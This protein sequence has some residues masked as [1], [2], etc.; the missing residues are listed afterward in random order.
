MAAVHGSCATSECRGLAV[1][2]VVLVL[3]G[4]ALPTT[5]QVDATNQV[6]LTLSATIDAS[7]ITI[8]VSAP[9]CEPTT[10]ENFPDIVIR[11]RNA[12]TGEVGEGAVAVGGFTAPGV[13]SAV[14]PSGTP[15]DSFLV[16]VTCN[17]GALEGSQAF[18]LAAPAP[19][20]VALQPNF[21]G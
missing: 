5:A 9:G 14:I 13:G 7:G 1:L 4:S 17:G 10:P 19:P 12:T 16:T 8:R 18:T 20:V 6:E 3:G 15:V 21:T 2:A 11:G